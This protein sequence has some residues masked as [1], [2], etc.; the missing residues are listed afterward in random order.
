[1]TRPTQRELAIGCPPE[2]S[3]HPDKIG[4][5]KAQALLLIRQSG[6]G[7]PTFQKQAAIILGR[8]VSNG[9]A[10]RHLRHYREVDNGAPVEAADG[11]KV[12]DLEI[13]DGI[14]EAGYRN[15]E[16][17]RPTIKDTL[18][19]LKLKL[20]LTGNSAFENMLDAMAAAAAGEDD[21]ET[22]AEEA[23]EAVLSPD[24]LEEPVF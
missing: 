5:D 22:E 7:A 23:P 6:A 14:I 16:R 15:R 13:I 18:D 17:W 24:E 10:G 11:P 3:L 1:M 2:C 19:A 4:E 12:T 9:T 20:Q 8:S 21:E